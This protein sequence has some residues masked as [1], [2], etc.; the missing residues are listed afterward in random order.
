MFQHEYLDRL[1]SLGEQDAD[2]NPAIAKF[3]DRRL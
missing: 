1:I 3:L 2:A